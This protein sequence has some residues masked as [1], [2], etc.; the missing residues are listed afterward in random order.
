M[1]VDALNPIIVK[2]NIK[3]NRKIIGKIISKE[4]IAN[5]DHW[6]RREII[7]LKKESRWEVATKAIYK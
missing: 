6:N 4:I 5:T 7:E 1:C 3:V 2:K